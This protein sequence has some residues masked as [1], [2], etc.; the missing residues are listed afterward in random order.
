MD[1]NT[2]I[3][4]AT[5]NNGKIKEFAR[6]LAP[7][8]L[9]VAGLADFPDLVEVEETGKTFEEN[10]LLKAA[11]ASKNTGLIAVSDDSGLMV[12]ALNGA[13]GIY[14]ARFS[15]QNGY[16]ATD[17]GNNKKLLELLNGKPK[18]E[19]EAK[20]VSVVAAVAPNGTHITATGEWAGFITTEAKG[21]NGFGYDPLFFDPETS[22]TAAQMPPHEKNARSH[23]AK[24]TAKLL[25]LWPDFWEK[26]KD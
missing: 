24:A 5:R 15:E 2:T 20:F 18:N 13:P 1:K 17:E 6:L 4:L 16:P 3:L 21:E 14:S 25:E 22:Q 19:R 7:F 23:R 9:Q 12:A 11:Y 8:G 26:V 10:A